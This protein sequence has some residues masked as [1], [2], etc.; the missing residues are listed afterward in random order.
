MQQTLEVIAIHG[1]GPHD[2]RFADEL[3]RNVIAYLQENG[4][5]DAH[6]RVYF[7]PVVW[8]DLGRQ[9]KE[10]LGRK[11]ILPTI[12]RWEMPWT[13]NFLL[14]FTGDIL[15]YLS[16]EGRERIKERVREKILDVGRRIRE[17]DGRIWEDPA[18]WEGLGEG[19]QAEWE[20][21]D[22]AYVSIVGHSLGSVITYD[23]AYDFYREMTAPEGE[24]TPVRMLKL[25]LSH[26][27]TMGSPL[28]LF[29]LLVDQ[30]H[31]QTRPVQV[32]PGGAWLNFYDRQDIIAYR[33]E[34]I[35]PA[36]GVQDIC[37]D[38]GIL[39]DLLFAFIPPKA[40]SFYWEN[41]AVAREIGLR[42]LADYQQ[43]RG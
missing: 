4:L 6:R 35:Y 5:P 16:A 39:Q 43:L 42:L 21:R 40:H 19:A 28:A 25:E 13:R 37:V 2:E 23:V 32:R 15:F 10:E 41:K 9:T 26:L 29:S 22:T 1:V 8:S 34:E 7:T 18:Y 14:D 24:W 11:L 31:Y 17:G 27:F 3:E 12:Q 38:P 33:L 30:A 20:S 36:S